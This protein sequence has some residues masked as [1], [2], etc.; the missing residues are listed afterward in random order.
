M[1]VLISHK[2]IPRVVGEYVGSPIDAVAYA[3]GLSRD[4]CDMNRLERSHE[5][6]EQQKSSGIKA[7]RL[8]SIISVRF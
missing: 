2:K 3:S 7:E 6:G 1:L 4:V 5:E 8:E